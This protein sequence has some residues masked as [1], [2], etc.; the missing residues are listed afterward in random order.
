M[1]SGSAFSLQSLLGSGAGTLPFATE[2]AMRLVLVK[3][4]LFDSKLHRDGEA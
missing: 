2:G 3:S 1:R 4:S